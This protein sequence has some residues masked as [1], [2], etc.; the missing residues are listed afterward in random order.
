MASSSAVKGKLFRTE[1]LELAPITAISKRCVAELA[2]SP[3]QRVGTSIIKD[4]HGHPIEY[5]ILN[6][7]SIGIHLMGSFRTHI[8]T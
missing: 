8:P 4:A 1:Y 6:H 3:T 5:Y 7:E 2:N